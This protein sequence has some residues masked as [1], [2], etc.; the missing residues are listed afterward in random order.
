MEMYISE[1]K[2]KTVSII[3]AA[4]VYNTPINTYLRYIEG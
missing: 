2:N 1:Y 3:D 4:I